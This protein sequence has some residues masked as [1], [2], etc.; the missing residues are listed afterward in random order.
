MIK[1]RISSPLT[2]GLSM[3]GGV[4][5]FVLYVLLALPPWGVVLAAEETFDILPWTDGIVYYKF[6]NGSF[7]PVAVDPC[8]QAK[9]ESQM[10]V[11]RQALTI[12]DPSGM[13]TKRYIDFRPYGNNSPTN[14]LVIR[15]NRLNAD[16]TEAECNNMSDPV[17]MEMRDPDGHPEGRSDDG[18][19]EL[20]FRRGTCPAEADAAHPA[21]AVAA[22][23]RTNQEDRIILHELGHALGFWHEFNRS[24]ADR[25]LMEVPDEDGDVFADSF[26]TKAGL[27]PALGNYDYDSIMHY[28]SGE[29]GGAPYY[30]DYL[31]NVFRKSD[32]GAVVSERD[33]SRLLQYLAHGRYPKWGFFRSWI[34]GARSALASVPIRP[35]CRGT[36]TDMM[37]L[38]STIVG[39]SSASSI[40]TEIGLT[41]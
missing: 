29:I 7:G 12:A 33:K 1:N 22:N 41:P 17:G 39:R 28:S 18:I 4:S 30:Y 19:T 5:L 24:D 6:D 20:H 16:G 15:Y 10:A 35:P 32:Q 2:Y 31:G 8:D 23:A 34:A 27:M 21:R 38:P 11:W 37:W 25:W 14:Y 3:S 40:S 13:G 36:A 26:G 9:I